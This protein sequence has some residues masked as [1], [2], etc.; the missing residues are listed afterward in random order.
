MTQHRPHQSRTSNAPQRLHRRTVPAVENACMT[1]TGGRRRA[2]PVKGQA[3]PFSELGVIVAG[4]ALGAVAWF[5]LVRAA[6]EFGGR[7]KGGDSM[8]WAF[9]AV[10]TLGA[11]VCLVLVLVLVGRGRELLG[12]RRSEG[13]ASNGGGRRRLGK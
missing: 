6:I 3:R 2:E 1:T 13:A 7:G 8:A 9:M 10:A 5:F 11:I 4:I 12:L